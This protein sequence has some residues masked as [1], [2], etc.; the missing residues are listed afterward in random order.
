MDRQHVAA[1][2]NLCATV[3]SRVRRA[4]ATEEQAAE[5]IRSWTDALVHVPAEASA[6]KWD[7]CHAVRRY[8]EQHGGDRS[9]QFRPIEPADILAAW[10]PHRA[11]LM[12]RHVDPAPAADP[13]D[14]HAY[15]AEL[16][17]T[18]AAVV[19]GEVAP[20]GQRQLSSHRRSS[21]TAARIAAMGSPIPPHVQR[22]LAPYRQ[23]RVRRREALAAQRLIV[24]A[25]ESCSEEGAVATS[26]PG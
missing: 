12:N 10:A 2:L 25:I 13:D 6:V 9:A 15:Q 5:T 23:F 1:L 4:M 17:A 3:D 7:A 14:V 16:R 21:E 24:P 11:E 20:A 22:Q 26:L 19:A 8:Y 18:R